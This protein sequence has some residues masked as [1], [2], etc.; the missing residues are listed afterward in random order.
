VSVDDLCARRH[1][2]AP[3]SDIATSCR[4]LSSEVPRRQSQ[5]ELRSPEPNAASRYEREAGVGCGA[6]QPTAQGFAY[7]EQRPGVLM[8]I[9]TVGLYDGPDAVLP[10]PA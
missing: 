10:E 7:L 2:D 4:D 3:R 9:D 1:L 5:P 6:G 8:Q